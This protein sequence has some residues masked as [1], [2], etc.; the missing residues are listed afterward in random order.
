MGV[1]ERMDDPV[2]PVRKSPYQDGS[3]KQAICK[4]AP[5]RKSWHRV[6]EVLIRK[7]PGRLVRSQRVRWPRPER[8][9]W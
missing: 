2:G 6:D 9:L 1:E 7:V 4:H 3:P 8:R 5:A